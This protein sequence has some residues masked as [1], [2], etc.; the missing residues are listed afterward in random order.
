VLY[1]H[2]ACG[3]IAHVAPCCSVC[4]E[5]MHSTDLDVEPGPGAAA[6]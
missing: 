5:P 2:R 3:E 6:G 4:G 1:R